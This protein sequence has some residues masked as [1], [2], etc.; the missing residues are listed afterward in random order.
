M[1][2]ALWACIVLQG[3]GFL[4]I[5][6]AGR[7]SADG[8]AALSILAAA[9]QE[10]LEP[11]QYDATNLRV[12]SARIG[13]GASPGEI[14]AF[15]A[16]LTASMRRYLHDVHAG[17]V[18]PQR[19]GFKID[20][21]AFEDVDAQLTAAAATHRVITA[22]E[23]LTPLSPA[24]RSLRAALA[25]YRALA[26]DPALAALALPR[27]AIHLGDRRAELPRLRHL[28]AA[29][30]DMP[31]PSANAPDLDRYDA[32][33]AA[34]VRRFQ[35]RHGLEPDGLIGAATRAALQVP[36]A[37]RVRQIELSMERLRWLPD[38]DGDRV[39]VVNIPMF[40]LWAIDGGGAGFTT[41][42]IVGRARSTRTPVFIESLEEVVFRPYWNVPESI[43]RHE[44]LPALQRDPAYLR[45]HD[46]EYVR[47]G[48]RL[49]VRQ[50][51]GPA[52]S[53]GLIKFAF[54]ND[55]SV[56]MHGTPAPQLF[57]RAR[58]D[59]SHG[60]IRVAD[61]VGL[62]EWVL[63]REARAWTREQILDAMNGTATFSV[64]LARPIRVVLFYLTAF[65]MPGDGLLHF[66]ED[67]YGH[68]ARLDRMLQTRSDENT[69]DEQAGRR[70]TGGL[71]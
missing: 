22:A 23:E 34:G 9:A 17:R 14:A 56:Y 12:S 45:R 15:D 6:G 33:L 37:H 31:L 16:A 62:G 32:D 29:L 38:R 2:F 58:R 10:G 69:T 49:R 36:L 27:S 24:Y 68:D 25:R 13:E 30:G 19:V 43:F 3:T 26:A 57:S 63:A 67:I 18:A 42:V 5:D 60:C 8:R 55:H 53:L 41:E 70:E 59:L 48:G 52:N 35:T 71:R 47:E 46:M 66:A 50:R 7:V 4:W 11:E 61:P 20:P 44:I 64:T 28:L 51:P 54:P 1:W 40:R 21:H 39:L 65:V